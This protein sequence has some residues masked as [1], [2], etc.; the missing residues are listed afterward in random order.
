M[1]R[2]MARIMNRHLFSLTS[3]ALPIF[4]AACASSA[5]QYPS[6][7]K[8]DAE[9]VSGIAE[10]AE[11]EPVTPM[12]P[13]P[14]LEN[15]LSSLVTKATRADRDFQTLKA[16]AERSVAA[17]RGAARAGESWTQ[18]QVT[19]AELQSARSDA[20][21][22]LADLDQLFAEERLAEPGELS[23]SALAIAD[24]RNRVEALVDQENRVIAALLK[25][26]GT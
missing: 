21:I 9:R 17:A 5:G 6:L 4:L 19:L 12:P 26:L 23:P 25:Q 15:R 16:P 20:M 14:H 1:A 8:R 22:A 18:A 11:A 2:A 24:A 7:A 3:L 13:G 10:P